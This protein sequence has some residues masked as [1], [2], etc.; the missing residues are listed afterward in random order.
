MLDQ[1]IV[2]DMAQN[3]NFKSVNLETAEFFGEDREQLKIEMASGKNVSFMLGHFDQCEELMNR[4]I[5]AMIA[6]KRKHDQFILS[7]DSSD[8][9][10]SDG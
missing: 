10:G 9:D 3:D 7:D 8:E 1:G 5:D 2:I 6:W 4:I